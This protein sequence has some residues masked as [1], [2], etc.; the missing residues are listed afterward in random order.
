MIACDRKRLEMGVTPAQY[1]KRMAML[2][3]VLASATVLLALSCASAS[4]ATTVS[5]LPE[6]AEA[7]RAASAPPAPG[8]AGCLA[9]RL[10]P[11]PAAARAR[12][13][14]LGVTR[15]AP[16]KSSTAAEGADG[17]RP[18]DLRSAYFTGAGE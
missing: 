7:V 5:P 16:L 17:L 8:S 3:T 11:Q 2:R 14:P 10:V 9:L 12:T 13:H 1:R 18:Q 15:S 6:S 4:A